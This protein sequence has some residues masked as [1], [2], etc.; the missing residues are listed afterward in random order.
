MSQNNIR[1]KEC[2]R[3]LTMNQQE[4]IVDALQLWKLQEELEMSRVPPKHPWRILWRVPR[5]YKDL[6]GLHSA[7][8]IQEEVTCTCISGVFEN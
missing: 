7:L 3:F 5:Q 2:F 6:L 8:V 1:R 4:S